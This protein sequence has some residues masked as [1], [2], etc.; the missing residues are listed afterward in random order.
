[1]NTF[2]LL[3]ATA[4]LAGPAAVFAHGSEAHDEAPKAAAVKEQ[5]PWGIAGDASAARRTITLDMSDNMRFTPERISVKRG[6]TVRLRVANKGQV[7]HEIVLGTPASLDEHAQMMLKFP[8]MEHGEPYMA[9]VSPGKSG[10]LVWNF[11]REGSFDFACLIPGHYQ[12]GMRG[13]IT[14]T[15]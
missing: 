6:E 9:H 13:T 11:N 12:A 15:Q 3:L 2:A 1:M 7:M 4:L 8:T 5:K 14:V 10:D